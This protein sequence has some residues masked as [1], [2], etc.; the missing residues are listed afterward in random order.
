MAGFSL[1]FNDTF[2]GDWKI[3]ML[4]VITNPEEKQAQTGTDYV[5]VVLAV[6]NDIQQ[7]MQT[8]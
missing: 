5:E 1:D 4:T 2:S 8:L 3:S 7:Q 6:R